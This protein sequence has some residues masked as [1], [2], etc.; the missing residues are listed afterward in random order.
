MRRS[1]SCIVGVADTL[2]HAVFGIALAAGV[3]CAVPVVAAENPNGVAV[4]VG[5]R[6]YQGSIPAVDFA[7]RD[8]AAIKRFVIDVLGF[9]EGNI[10]D[11]RD[12]TQADLYTAFGSRDDHKGK[13][14][15]WAR[16]GRS[17]VVV[18]YSGHG[19]PGKHRRG[20]LLPVDADPDTPEINGYSVDLLYA[21]LAKID[22]RSVT[23]Y[24]DA[25]FS[26]ESPRG[27]LIKAVSGISVVPKLP[28]VSSG[29]TVLTAAQGDQ[30][31]SW[32][33][34][35]KHGLFTEYL[36]RALYGAADSKQ[37]GEEDCQVTLSEIQAY[38]DAEMTYAARRRYRREQNASALGD[39]T[40]VLVAYPDGK[41][42]VRPEFIDDA[43]EPSKWRTASVVIAPKPQIQLQP[44]EAA[45]VAVKNA[46]VRAEPS[47]SST[48]V[49]TLKKGTDVYVPGSTLDG[50][51]LRVELDGKPIGYVYAPLLEDKETYGERLAALTAPTRPS[52]VKP[53]V[54]KVDKPD[55]AALELV[56][57]EQ[58]KESKNA[59]DFDAF[60][61]AHPDGR[62]SALDKRLMAALM[63]PA[64]PTRPSPAK[65]AVGQFFRPGDTLRDC[66]R[67]PEMIVI[68]AGSFMMGSNT[69]DSNEKPVRRVTFAR[70]FASETVIVSTLDERWLI[71]LKEMEP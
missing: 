17:D 55:P 34:E 49:A 57:W 45:Y 64:P 23:V 19:V 18:F 66:Q 9:R 59:A 46:N 65:P 10:I 38:L 51:W 1:W 39:V 11:L 31:A 7:H 70:P 48:K 63:T 42:P 8:A 30:L 6:N 29:L 71:T 12:A 62:F 44:V 54:A 22:A 50:Q 15:G 53:A 13:L 58:I 20:Y 61:K 47:V 14:W 41:V 37:Y 40:T 69:G 4:I 33:E 5:N 28:K 60:L 56:A 52:P 67:C 36:L 25:C 32:D 16:E 24:L 43:L 68:P 35:A 21:N 2:R 26:G 27:M 3:V